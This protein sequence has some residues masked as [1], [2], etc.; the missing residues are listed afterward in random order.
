MMKKGFI[1]VLRRNKNMPTR[2]KEPSLH[3]TIKI[4]ALSRHTSKETK[5]SRSLPRKLHQ[6]TFSP[7]LSSATPIPVR[8][9]PILCFAL[10]LSI[11]RLYKGKITP[12]RSHNTISKKVAPFDR[13]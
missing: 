9:G 11:R 7:T 6:T 13:R 1:A 5:L 12:N 10:P 3:L 4:H 8:A 2:L